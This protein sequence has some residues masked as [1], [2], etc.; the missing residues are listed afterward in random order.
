[1][2]EGGKERTKDRREGSIK[3]EAG[4]GSKQEGTMDLDFV[5]RDGCRCRPPKLCLIKKGIFVEQGK[6]N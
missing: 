1:M 5:V 6:N 4:Q 2:K 3:K